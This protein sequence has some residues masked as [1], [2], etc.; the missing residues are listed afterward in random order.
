MPGSHVVSLLTKQYARLLGELEFADRSIMDTGAGL[1]A[2]DEAIYAVAALKKE[3]GEK[4]AAIE[5]VIWMYDEN[6]DPSAIRPNFPRQRHLKPGAISRAA[7]AIL[8]DAKI[9]MT[10]REIARVAA[11]RLGYANADEREITRIEGAVYGALDKKVGVTLEIVQREP[12][13]WQLIPRDQVR[14]RTKARQIARA[15]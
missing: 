12:I 3:I 11:A 8:R 1:A 9:P 7:Y 15:A 14:S 13:R 4:L 2:F 5:V 6:W 10:T